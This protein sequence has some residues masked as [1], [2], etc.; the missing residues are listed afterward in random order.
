MALHVCLRD[1]GLCFEIVGTVAALMNSSRFID[2]A[3]YRSE[4]EV[5]YG[6]RK[7]STTVGLPALKIWQ[8]SR[9]FHRI[10]H[11]IGLFVW[12]K[13]FLIFSIMGR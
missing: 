3:R 1:A 12:S 8:E 11:I 2:Y 10:L 6:M 4:Q 5:T 9:P 13:R 7:K